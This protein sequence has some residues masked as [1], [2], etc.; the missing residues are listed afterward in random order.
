MIPSSYRII[1]RNEE[2]QD[3]ATLA[4]APEGEPLHPAQPG[5]FHMLYAFGIGEVP[6]S[7]SGV[8]ELPIQLHTLRAVGA[9]TRALWRAQ[10]GTVLGIRGPF[11][12]GWR[13]AGVDADLVI[14]AGGIGL[15]PLRPVIHHAM[16][17]RHRYRNVSV[18]IG[19]RTPADLLYPAEYE[20]WR[21]AGLNISSTVDVPAIGWDGQVGVVTTLVPGAVT[22]PGRTAALICGPEVMMRF[23]ARA[24][25]QQGVPASAIQV[26]LERNM[27]C[28]IGECGHCQLGP[29]LLCRDGPI[30]GYD[31]A[32][33]LLSVKEL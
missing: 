10:P 25:I 9:V 5:Q 6:I 26:S 13:L 22:D 30:A 1:H 11:G 17:N 18:L 27:R 29:L 20:S 31:M 3:T 19:A 15:A 21:E 12:N 28:G 32:E 4:L 23:A 33:P 24:L 16:A 7:V 14:V 8:A 2:T